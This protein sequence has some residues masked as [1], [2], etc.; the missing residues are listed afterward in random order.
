VAADGATLLTT[1]DFAWTNQG[2]ASVTD[3]AG[4]IVL[5]APASSGTNFR[6][7]QRAAPAPTWSLIAAI[8]GHLQGINGSSCNPQVAILCRQSTSGK[9]ISFG[10]NRSSSAAMRFAVDHWTNATTFGGST[11]FLGGNAIFSSDVVWFKITDN[12]TNLIFSVSDDGVEWIQ[13]LSQS[14]SALMT[15]NG[16]VTGPDQIGFGIN[17][18]GDAAANDALLRLVHWHVE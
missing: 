6:I 3:L 5:R 12:N 16:G 17:N 1:S 2:G 11:P 9:F 7:Q 18:G 10:F 13:V 14:R 8:R 15:L 4:T